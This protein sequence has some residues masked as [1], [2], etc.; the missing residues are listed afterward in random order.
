[1]NRFIFL[2]PT[3]WLLTVG[4][5]ATAVPA[6]AVREKGHG[7]R[8]LGVSSGWTVSARGAGGAGLSC[9]DHHQCARGARLGS[10]MHYCVTQACPGSG[11]RYCVTQACPGS[12]MRY[13]VTQA[14]PGSDI[15]YC[16]TQACPASGNPYFFKWYLI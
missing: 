12:G 6:P 8:L 11:M 16:V 1:M 5:R 3:E 10:G 2:P 9:P 7:F 14:C 15:R 4:D 13:C